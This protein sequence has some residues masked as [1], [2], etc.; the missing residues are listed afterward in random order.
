MDPSQCWTCGLKRRQGRLLVIQTQR[1]LPL[2]PRV[3]AFGQQMIV[4]PAALLK[5]LTEKAWLLLGRV[6]AVLE[7]LTYVA[8]ID[9]RHTCCQ[10]R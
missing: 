3:A 10:A 7:R 1:L 5:L 2:L 4:E 9:L 6:Q 8:I